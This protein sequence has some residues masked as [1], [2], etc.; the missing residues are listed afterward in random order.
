M[1]WGD[2]EAG[3]LV[4]TDFVSELQSDRFNGAPLPGLGG[5]EGFVVTPDDRHVY[6]ATPH[7]GGGLRGGTRRGV[8]CASDHSTQLT[9]PSD[10]GTCH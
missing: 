5:P 1:A 9:A 6:L 2:A 4:G 7:P 3:E 8:V 10:P